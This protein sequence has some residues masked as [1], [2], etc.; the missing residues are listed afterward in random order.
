MAASTGTSR[1]AGRGTRASDATVTV[2]KIAIGVLITVVAIPVL[3]IAI[4]ASAFY[5]IFYFPNRTT[6]VAGTIV[7]SGDTRE[8]LL[9]VP[10]SYDPSKPAPLVISLHPAMSWPA[11]QM[12]FSRWNTVAD[13][14]GILVVYPSGTGRG[15]KVWFMRGRATPSRMPDVVFISDLIDR[16]A[17]S[18]AVDRTRIYV[19]GF[20]NGGGMAFVLSCTL[21][22]RIA[23]VGMVAAARS[24]DFSWCTD[25]RPM[26]S[27]AFHGTA[28]AFASYAGGKTPVGPDVFPAV[29]AFTADWARR[30]RCDSV[31]AESEVAEDV[32]RLDYTDCADDADVV[33]YTVN[34]G[35]HQWPGGRRLPEFL[36]G[37]YSASVNATRL[38]WEFFS[39][40]AR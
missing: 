29:R 31:A 3:L 8:Y 1:T 28:D 11:A 39:V 21:S 5:A 33:L 17:A 10:P 4:V 9:Y 2:K 32:V 38:M 12:E 22:D 40:H 36:V 27:I 37:H 35:G 26:P 23:A 16:I 18:Y 25:R 24:L 6:A 20:S 30:N 15:P 13:E 34:G 19:D 7:S 14:H